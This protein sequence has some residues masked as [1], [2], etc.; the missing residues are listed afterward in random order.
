MKP[1]LH[2]R[3]AW[4][5]CSDMRC[6]SSAT[7][8]ARLQVC[9]L[10]RCSH[11][12]PP[13]PCAQP[14]RTCPPPG[15]CCGLDE[16]AA[17][18]FPP[19]PPPPPPPPTHPPTPTHPHTPPPPPHHHHHHTHPPSCPQVN[20]LLT[21]VGIV[22]HLRL[23]LPIQ[24]GSL[25]LTLR[26]TGHRCLQ[27]CGVGRAYAA[28]AAAAAGSCSG[29]CGLAG[30]AA[31]C[32]AGA[33]GAAAAAAGWTRYY[34]ASNSVIRRLV[35]RQLWELAA[36]WRQRHRPAGGGCLGACFATHALLQIR[37]VPVVGGCAVP[38]GV[39]GAL[40][41]GCHIEIVLHY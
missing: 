40:P 39:V 2:V 23:H 4:L 33:G 12:A 24:V 27:E 38:G 9:S 28:A 11:P 21:T 36:R 41:P 3:V 8:S 13:A 7:A 10:V 17:A 29:G 18:D 1:P 15:R 5:L 16:A 32:P 14:S 37:P 35:P 26:S 22:L 25:V 34:S 6:T 19:P 30:S 31:T 20:W